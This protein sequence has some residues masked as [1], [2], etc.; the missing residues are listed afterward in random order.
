MAVFTLCF[1]GTDCWPDESLTDRSTSGGS[2]PAIYGPAGYIPSKIYQDIVA[3]REQGKETLPGPGAA[4][5]HLWQTLWVPCSIVTTGGGG[6][7]TA[8]GESMW[9]LAGHGAAYVLGVPSKGRGNR[10]SAPIAEINTLIA[11]VRR[12]VGADVN[13]DDS[14]KPTTYKCFRFE[15][16]N[17]QVLM[18]HV[19]PHRNGGGS[20]VTTI[21]LI[22]HSRGGVAAIMCAHDLFYLFPD[23]EVNLF[24]IDPVPGPGTLTQEMVLL[25]PNVRNYV[26]VY[27]VDETSGM[28]NGVVPRPIH[29]HH[30]IDPL[31]PTQHEEQ[32]L[33]PPRYHLI[34]APGRHGTVAG[35]RTSDGKAVPSKAS[36]AVSKVGELINMLARA[37]LRAWGTDVPA[38][39]YAGR[40]LHNLRAAMTTNAATYRNMRNFT[41]L[42][43][44][45]HSPQ[46]WYERGV[47]S[48]VGGD[49]GDWH[50][51]EDAIGAAPLVERKSSI[52]N[53]L[54]EDR[55]DPG[56][57]RWESLQGVHDEAFTR[58]RWPRDL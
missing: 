4:W 20:A 8:S 17:L 49:S 18:D 15:P 2:A 29:N 56:R 3:S 53:F 36:P 55:P 13:H 51:L 57:V 54:R 30:Y 35:N 38:A 47:T 58:G 12:D 10:I 25:A 22:G 48:D 28:F 42:P 45:A 9:D 34:Y 52:P 19:Q 11:N 46:H 16:S 31:W 44:D 14:R 24:A 32:R 50:Y 1:S 6:R 27:A 26:G 5:G 39:S 41:Y 37:C 43:G 7:D 33:D 23:A 40:A 21:N